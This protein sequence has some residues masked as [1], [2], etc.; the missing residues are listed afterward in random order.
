MCSPARSA[1]FTGRTSSE[2][3]V[4]KN[5]RSIRKGIPNIGEWFQSETDYETA[6]A[7]KWH[8]PGT[9]THFIDGFNVLH[10]GIMGQGNVCDTAVSRACANFIRNRESEKPFFLVASFMQPHDICE[11]LRLN[12]ETPKDLLYPEIADELPELPDNFEFTQDEPEFLRSRRQR[13]D[14]AK[15]NWDKRQWR[16]YRW[17]YYRH[18]EQVDGEVGRLLEALD[19][20]G[21]TKNTLI[22]FTSDHGEG[23]GHHQMVRKS[24]PYDEASKVPLIVS[25]PGHIRKNKTDAE[26]LVTG[27]DLVPTLCDYAGIA[28]PPKMR[29]KSLRPLLEGKKTDWR[30]Y[31]VVEVPANSGRVL[32]TPRYKYISF[33]N[34]PA[35]LLFDMREDP[36]ETKNLAASPAHRAVLEEHKR[37]LSEWES[38]LDHGPDLPNA[39]AWILA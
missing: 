3:G 34:D 12:T 6:Y 11:W 13:S 29:G 19:E 17:S 27:L 10:T 1:I 4:Y 38:Q 18:I 16:Y 36:G 31:I 37:L 26:H 30:P 2:T 14:P 15:G 33:Y 35:D 39:D 28:P 21:Q 23:M 24:Q 9:Y 22:V 7:G 5:G 25:W 8:V 32:R 20:A